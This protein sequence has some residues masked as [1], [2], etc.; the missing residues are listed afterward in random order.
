MSD[1]KVLVQD[2]GQEFFEDDFK[3]YIENTSIEDLLSYNV[4]NRS[5]FLLNLIK[6]DLC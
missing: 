6:I 4:I 2:D 1:V 5:N 3:N